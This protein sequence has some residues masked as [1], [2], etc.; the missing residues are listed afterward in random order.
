M[1][2]HKERILDDHLS[3]CLPNR[4]LKVYFISNHI[5][6]SKE[7]YWVIREEVIIFKRPSIDFNGKTH[8]VI[9][10]KNTTP[11][12]SF[13]DIKLEYY[14]KYGCYELEYDETEDE[15]YLEWN[16]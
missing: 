14:L 3:A 11:V 13:S 6:F 5:F 15:I 10:I 8:N 16:V 4:H 2:I 9:P 12:F 1:G 7:F